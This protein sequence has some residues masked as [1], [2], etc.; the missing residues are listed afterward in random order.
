MG[1]EGPPAARGRAATQVTPRDSQVSRTMTGNSG[2]VMYTI[3]NNEHRRKEGRERTVR[4][5]LDKGRKKRRK[6]KGRRKEERERK[7]IG[8]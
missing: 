6:G 1:Q 5:T 8:M 2:E 7:R 4:T 3:N